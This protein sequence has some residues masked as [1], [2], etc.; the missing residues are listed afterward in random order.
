MRDA[1]S[2]RV[3][4]RGELDLAGAPMVT[5]R[6]LRLRASGEP[7]VLDLDELE[8]IDMSGLRVVRAAADEAA[9]D[10]WSFAITRGSPSVRRL[11][12]LVGLDGQIPLDGSRR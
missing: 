7:V 6:L 1:E 3:H 2:V 10:G 9:R 12:A 11:M 4:L 8:F 5:E